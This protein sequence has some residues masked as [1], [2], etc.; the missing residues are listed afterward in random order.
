LKN[1][2]IWRP[3]KFVYGKHGL[4]AS[5]DPSQVSISSRLNTD[6][7]ARHY[8]ERLPKFA[9]GKLLDL[10]C[11]MV[12]LF[13]AYRDLV[14]EVTCVDWGASLHKNEYLDF[15]CDLNK[16]LPFADGEFDTLILSDVLEHIAEPMALWREIARILNSDGTLIMN[17]PFIY[18]LHEQPHDYYR[19]TEFALRRF[20][21]SV[22]MTLIDLKATGGVP[23]VLADILSKSL[24]RVPLAGGVAAS[25]IQW[26][27]QLFV[28]TSAGQRLSSKT[29]AQFPLGYFLVARKAR[30]PLATARE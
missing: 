16:P 25:F 9:R 10:G 15:E 14:T 26:A 5:R 4:R 24:V 3:S 13:A 19:Y 7:T 28:K 12:P 1:K 17:V 23:E 29:A 21:E 11:G 2:E 22:N 6:I 27:T 8:C 30:A 18:W 20:V